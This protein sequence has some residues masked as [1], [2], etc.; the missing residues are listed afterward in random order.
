MRFGRRKKGSAGGRPEPGEYP[1]SFTR[2]FM[3]QTLPTASPEE[4]REVVER[5]RRKGW[6]EDE[7]EKHLLPYMPVPREEPRRQEDPD[8]GTERAVP[9]DGGE[10][11]VADGGGDRAVYVPPRVSRAWLDEHLPGMDRRELRLV[12]EELERRGWSPP[13]AARAV[14]P[15]LLPKLPAADRE[16]ILA[17]LTELGLSDDEIARLATVR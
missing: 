13:D 3:R 14:L 10:R 9:G 8:D 11:A 1:P 16:A 5:M 7:V 4:A 2:A 17:G 12:V 6:T 15:H